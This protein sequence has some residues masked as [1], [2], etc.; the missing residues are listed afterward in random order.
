ML[1]LITSASEHP[2]ATMY[3]GFRPLRPCVVSSS[4]AECRCRCR[5]GQ[6][7][8][9]EHGTAPGEGQS[10]RAGVWDAVLCA[11]AHGGSLP[12][13]RDAGLCGRMGWP[14]PASLT[15]LERIRLHGTVR[16]SLVLGLTVRTWSSSRRSPSRR[17]PGRPGD[18][19]RLERSEP[20]AA[21]ADGDEGSLLEG[22][23]G[24]GDRHRP[25]EACNGLSSRG[26]ACSAQPRSPSSAGCWQ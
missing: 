9:V 23:A 10:S 12:Q 13:R 24:P 4:G 17:Q 19:G 26:R 16:P 7:H 21:L 25:G 3:G 5:R 6:S 15:H 11:A 1:R 22:V 8:S 20:C 2:R 18:P 14:D